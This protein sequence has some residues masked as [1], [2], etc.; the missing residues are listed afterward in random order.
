MCRYVCLAQDFKIH[1]HIEIE[2]SEKSEDVKYNLYI[3]K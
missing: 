2:N 3:M 1:V